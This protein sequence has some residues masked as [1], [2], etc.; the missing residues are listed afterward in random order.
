MKLI[1]SWLMIVLTLSMMGCT[2]SP[3]TVSGERPAPEKNEGAVKISEPVKKARNEDDAMQ[4]MDFVKSLKN[5]WNL[6]NTLDAAAPGQMARPAASETAWGNPLT[7]Q[8][9]IALLPDAGFGI[10]RVPAT[11]QRHFGPGPDYTVDPAWMSRVQEVVDYGINSGLTVILNLHH[12]DWH[13]PSEENYPAASGILKKLWAQIAENFKDYDERLIFEAMNEP[14]M[15]NTPYEWTGGTVESRQVVNK[16]NADFVRTIR[17]QGGK[18]PERYL[19]IPTYAASAEDKC[20]KELSIPDDSRI[21]VSI[22]AY[23]PYHFALDTGPGGTAEWSADRPEDT[24]DID[25]VLARLDRNFTSKGIPVIMGEFGAVNRNNLDRVT[26]CT[27]YYCQKARELG[28]PMVWW[29]NGQLTP[30]QG[31]VFGIM[32]RRGN[33]WRY[34]EVVDALLN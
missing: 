24:R 20:M 34:Q 7:T 31:E 2:K 17:G 4:T 22:H 12:E 21:I 3:D 6:G 29:D 11:W 26:A 15:N 10:L 14:R 28:V 25:E 30:G 8:E 9:M 33:R 18:N 1:S 32:D 23:V 13:F 19:M 27:R 5:G 16:L